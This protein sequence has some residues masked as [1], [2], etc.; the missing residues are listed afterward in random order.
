V[1]ENPAP[2][3]PWTFADAVDA[4]RNHLAALQNAPH[5]EHFGPF[6]PICG[7]TSALLIRMEEWRP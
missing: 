6:C 2:P 4:I 7:L 5:E 3:P 1:A